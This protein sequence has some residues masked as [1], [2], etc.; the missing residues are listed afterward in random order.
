MSIR[1]RITLIGLGVV[2]LVLCCFSVTLFGLVSSGLT[3][4]RDKQLSQRAEGA[5]SSL[6]LA[7]RPD[8]APVTDL[9]PVDVS[10][11][12]DIFV[13]VLDSSG[14][15]LR[16][17]G[18]YL[19]APPRIPAQ[20]L[21]QADRSGAV[22]ATV[23]LDDA[24]GK[25]GRTDPGRT[26]L[27][28]QIRT[29]SRADLGLRGYAVAAQNDKQIVQN[30]NGL[31]VLF[32]ISGLVAFAASAA[33]VW[34]AAGRALAP[35]RQTAALADE[36]GRSQDL[37]RRLPAV[38][39]NDAV[40][41]LTRSFNQMMDRL[42]EAYGRVA[43]A[44]AVQQRFTADASHELRT[45][46][47]TIRNNAEFLLQHPHAAAEDRDAALR[48]IAGEGVRMSRMVENLLTLARADSGV[49]LRREPVDL[50][51]LAEQVCR[52]AAGLPADRVLSCTSTPARPVI[53][54]EDVLR[55]LLWILLDNAV[56]FTVDSGRIW[57]NVTQRGATVA[58]TVA[59]DG[60]G[61]PPGAD[62]RIFDRFYRADPAR[63]GTGAGLGLA[64]AAWAVRVHGGTIVA[65]NNDHGGATFSVDLPGAPPGGVDLPG[66]PPGG[67]DLP[68]ASPGGVDLR[69]APP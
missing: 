63:R 68:G 12:V 69:G 54:D 13:M 67:V 9:A 42:Q 20:L 52:Q 45:P 24:G 1:T 27:R 15:V 37:G 57:V 59:D 35:L 32:V 49:T 28:V 39:S 8:L 62:H 48:D 34:V 10:S 43:S 29:W 41:R 61:L 36:V 64:I 3:T 44:L 16:S 65:A 7:G 40:G 55:Q 66:A 31:L 30:R 26:D 56:K 51:R 33:A 18:S 2:G 17:G 53:G 60:T 25:A 4:D 23:R 22:A 19:G 5:V 14:T 6:A 21:A 58:L 50:A 46:L 38:P 11:S 47:T